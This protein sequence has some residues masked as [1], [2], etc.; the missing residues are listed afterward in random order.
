[1]PGAELDLRFA[2]R[3]NRKVRIK[4]EPAHT[5]PLGAGLF[6]NA[7]PATAG[8][9]DFAN[10]IRRDDAAHT[11]YWRRRLPPTGSP[12]SK[13]WAEALAWIHGRG[14]QV[15][16]AAAAA[17]AL[18]FFYAVVYAFPNARLAA[19]QQARD[20]A[21]QENR[22]F[23]E[24]HGMPFGTREHTVCAEDLMDIRAN[25]RQRTLDELGIF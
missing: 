9:G 1:V 25:E 21:E 5:R 12:R 20:A 23:C 13:T 3:A 24:K 14:N 6:S 10:M 18:L 2:R 22:A 7:I 19:L 11:Q 15:A 16:W 17:S 4:C 8:L